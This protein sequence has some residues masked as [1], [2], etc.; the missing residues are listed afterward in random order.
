MFKHSFK[1]TFYTTA[2]QTEELISA[3]RL[4]WKKQ[5]DKMIKIK[6]I[7]LKIKK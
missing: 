2:K 7:D 5:F 1:K 6:A 4:D 3:N